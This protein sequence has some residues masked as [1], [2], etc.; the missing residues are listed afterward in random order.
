MALSIDLIG[1]ANAGRFAPSS[2]RTWLHR[3]AT[4]RGHG[5]RDV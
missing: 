1:S 3:I 5:T 2:I 4:R